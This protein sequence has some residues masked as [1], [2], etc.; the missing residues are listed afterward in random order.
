MY[1]IIHSCKKKWI[2]GQNK[3]VLWC[4]LLHLHRAPTHFLPVA[5]AVAGLDW[6]SQLFSPPRLRGAC[7]RLTRAVQFTCVSG[8]GLWTRASLLAGARQ[9]FKRYAQ[10]SAGIILFSPSIFSKEK[11]KYSDTRP[12]LGC[13]IPRSGFFWPH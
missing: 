9:A 3:G 1:N 11:H 2:I 12:R 5:V 7:E 4:T 8:G 6:V 13:V 10:K